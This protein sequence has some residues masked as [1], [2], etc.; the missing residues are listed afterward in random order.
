MNRRKN[1]AHSLHGP[2]RPANFNQYLFEQVLSVAQML[3][4]LDPS[5]DGLK[6]LVGRAF[7]FLDEVSADHSLLTAVRK[8]KAAEYRRQEKQLAAL[9]RL[10][11]I[12]DFQ[13]AVG[14]IM[15]DR[16]F[17]VEL[18]KFKRFVRSSLRLRH[19]FELNG[20]TAGKQ[21]ARWSKLKAI[22]LNQVHQL[23]YVHE[24]EVA[25]ARKKALAKL[26]KKRSRKAR[27]PTSPRPDE[28][29]RS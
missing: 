22:P 11:E 8:S 26:A 19:Y 23:Y 24:R 28:N 9:K 25:N 16:H 15:H 13:K 27:L 29:E 4:V 1:K 17:S 3:F 12:V 18:P 20:T 2:R 14:L 7:A 6:K 21:L 10:P 5:K